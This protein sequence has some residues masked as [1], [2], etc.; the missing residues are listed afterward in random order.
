MA[1]PVNLRQR[2]MAAVLER[3][4]ES[5]LLAG[6]IFLRWEGQFFG[7]VEKTHKDRE[8]SP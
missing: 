8:D 3:G 1:V 5:P 4:G 2:D 7:N 6:D